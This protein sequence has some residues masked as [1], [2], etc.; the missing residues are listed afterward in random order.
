MPV[1]PVT[2]L[3]AIILC[4]VAFLLGIGAARIFL[5]QKRTPQAP[6]PQPEEKINAIVFDAG[7]R[8]HNARTNDDVYNLVGR[9]IQDMLGDAFIAIGESDASHTAVA[10][11]KLIGFDAY[12]E[13]MK[14]ILGRKAFETPYEMKDIMKSDAVSPD[15]RLRMLPE[16]LFDLTGHTVPRTVCGLVETIL[17]IEK[18][19]SISFSY[20]GSIVGGASILV[21]RGG[22]AVDAKA[23][24]SLARQ[25]ALVLERI[26]AEERLSQSEEKLRTMIDT[27]PYPI[28]AKSADMRYTEC[29]KAFEAYLGKMREEIIGKTVYEVSPPDKAAVYDAAD[30][31]LWKSKATQQYDGSVRYH[32]GTDHTVSF[33]KGIIR[34]TS[35][36]PNG[37]IGVMYDITDRIAMEDALRESEFRFREMADLLPLAIYEADMTGR[38]TFANR[39]AHELFGYSPGDVANG[40]SVIDTVVPEDRERARTGIAN[41]STDS[42]HRSEYTALRKDGKRIPVAIVYSVIVKNGKVCGFRGTAAD[43]SEQKRA[44]DHMFRESVRMGALARIAPLDDEKAIFDEALSASLA[45]TRSDI[46]Y[47][48]FYDEAKKLFEIFSWS[49]SVMERCTVAEPRTVYQLE[50]TGI[51]GDV[52]RERRPLIVNDF[53]A[54]G[55]RRVGYPE[56]HVALTRFLSV[57]V[58]DAERIVA[59]VGVANKVSPYDDFDERQLTELMHGVWQVVT[60]KRAEHARIDSDEK[61]R[62]LTDLLPQSVFETDAKGVITFINTQGIS[63]TGYSLDDFTNGFHA[64]GFVIPADR[65]RVGENMRAVAEGRMESGAGNEYTAMCKD[66]T[67]YPVIIYSSPRYV[68]GVFAG[69][70]G[71]AIDISERKKFEEELQRSEARF[72]NI[73]EAAP[74]GMHFCELKDTR[75]VFTGA[76]AFADRMLNIDHRAHVGKSIEA[77]MPG[78][79][80]GIVST[81]CTIAEKGGIW[82]NE[83]SEFIDH[84]LLGMFDV[85]AF[86]TSPGKMVVA[87]ADVSERKRM[88]KELSA[89]EDKYRTLVRNL[90]DIVL[91]HEA[92]IIKYFNDAIPEVTG[93]AMDD[94]IGR[95]IADFIHPDDV[96]VAFENMKRRASGEEVPFVYDLRLITKSGAVRN[97][98]IRAALVQFEGRPAHLSVL[99]DITERK[100]AEEALKESEAKYRA[101]MESSLVGLYIIQDMRFRYVNNAYA[102]LFGYHPDEMIDTMSPVDLVVPEIRETVRANLTRRAD[103]EPGMP[104]DIR[105]VRRDGSAFDAQV[106]GKGIMYQ[107]RPASVGS[108]ID[109]TERTKTET[110]LRE[111]EK[112]FRT[113]VEHINDAFFVHD[114]SGVISD[115]NDIAC[116]SLGYTRSELIGM[117]LKDID[118]PEDIRK[119]GERMRSLTSQG[120]V[121]FDAE[122]VR[123]DGSSFPVTVSASIISHEEGGRVQSFVRDITERMNAER[124]LRDYTAEIERSNR[125]LQDF[126]YVASHDLQEPLRKVRTFGDRLLSRYASALSEEGRGYIESIQNSTKRMQTLI[127]DLLSYS[128]IG[129]GNS[130]SP[131][132]LDQVLDEALQAL[133]VSIEEAH[134]RIERTALPVIHAD[135]T[136]MKQLFQN[137]IGNAVKFRRGDTESVVRISSETTTDGRIRIIVEDNGIG[138]DDRYRDKIFTIFQRLHTSDE[139]AGTGVGLAICRKIVM[140]HNGSIEANGIVGTGARF[141]VTLPREQALI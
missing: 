32:D 63:A 6:S 50:T 37:I 45:V 65:A 107:G 10:L 109:I 28:F 5:R 138:F 90:P 126:A 93:Y 130:F 60:R 59:V 96:G 110:V 119:I 56:G 20:Y 25:A 22:A 118:A 19:Y 43:I 11:V 24:E 82:T 120:V 27:I 92:G 66:G 71:I 49:K 113:I 68:D 26:R 140:R 73:V 101:V 79:D 12:L 18:V 123:K 97:F 47:I 111:S 36:A 48:Y 15:G 80:A 132:S 64:S 72:R 51:W 7:I 134:A 46:G 89:S 42:E 127:N 99:T 124:R 102:D 53:A 137:L 117:S 54:E 8:L 76:N 30:R 4:A 95:S 125:E 133:A 9:A 104:Y 84:P 39:K 94:L 34:N 17:G 74:W 58:F 75:L 33:Y 100:A 2:V 13:Q 128:R 52:V 31:A 115:C 85:Y 135:H 105:C 3:Y 55:T 61:F 70:R 21:R 88:Q 116:R 69:L 114:L 129:A 38:I 62:E 14:K 131:V 122:H 106:W 108:L 103:G 40:L 98:E 81:F 83:E 77:V 86:Q 29:N 78:L 16:K 87:F 136:Q 44:E 112:R 35:G 141:S 41:I 1:L 139:Y 67:T 57:P 23:I 121:E 91:V